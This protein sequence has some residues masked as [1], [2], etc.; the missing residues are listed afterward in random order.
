MQPSLV[1]SMLP[2]LPAYCQT[3]QASSATSTINHQVL[4]VSRFCSHLSL[5]QSLTFLL[6]HI[7]SLQCQPCFSLPDKT[8]VPTKPKCNW[9][10]RNRQDRMIRGFN[11]SFCR[12]WTN[13][14]CLLFNLEDLLIPLQA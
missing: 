1:S 12:S 9:F 6:T 5:P 2:T 10:A 4:T 8:D 13:N 11:V 14:E 3:N 7:R